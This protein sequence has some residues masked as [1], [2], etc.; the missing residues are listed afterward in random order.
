MAAD[1]ADANR[2]VRAARSRSPRVLA[3]VATIAAFVAG[4]ALARTMIAVPNFA[5]PTKMLLAATLEERGRLSLHRCW[6][7][8]D[9]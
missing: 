9:G 7:V 2:F 3:I 1:R 5:N 8:R 6:R 4:V